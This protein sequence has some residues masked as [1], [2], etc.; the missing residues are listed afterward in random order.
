MIHNEGLNFHNWVLCYHEPF[1]D[2]VKNQ[3]KISIDL[4]LQNYNH[5]KC[6]AHEYAN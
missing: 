4:Y 2:N 6:I 1:H 3:R 5:V